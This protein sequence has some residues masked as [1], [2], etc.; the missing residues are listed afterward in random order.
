M[1]RQTLSPT[2]IL[3]LA[4]GSA[5][6][7]R[8]TTINDFDA[9]GTPYAGANFPSPNAMP[10][11]FETGPDAFSSGEFLRLKEFTTSGFQRSLNAVGFDQTD[12]GLFGRIVIDFDFRVTC[13]GTRVV[14]SGF[15]FRCADGFS[16]AL[17]NTAKWG[18]SG[19]PFP[20]DENGRANFSLVGHTESFAVGFNTFDNL[21]GSNNSLN[22]AF[23]D[24]FISAP[25]HLGPLGFDIVTGSNRVRGDFQHAN[26]DLVLA[27]PTPKVTVTLTDGGG[28]SITPF[29]NFDLSSVVVAGVPFGPYD[30]RLGFSTRTGDSQESVDLDNVQV[31]YLDPLGVPAPATLALLGFG[32]AG[33]AVVRRRRSAA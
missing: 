3:A 28:T 33:L 29:L 12:P 10:A 5:S 11:P 7:A 23:N 14:G 16:V 22:L 9:A 8:A 26:I 32:L 15:D 13:G 4:L 30:A 18:A 21:E 2:L 19:I 25:T 6:P 1:F 17:F 24:T 31:R 20:M 27:G